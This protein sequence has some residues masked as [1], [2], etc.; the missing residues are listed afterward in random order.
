MDP[1]GFLPVVSGIADAI[2]GN[3]NAQQARDAYKSRYQDTVKDIK[4]AGLNPALAYGQGG[5]NPQTHD[6]PLPGEQTSKAAQQFGAANT[7]KQQAELIKTQND[8]LQAQKT[9]IILGTQLK[10]KLLNE[11]IGQTATSAQEGK[12]RINE[13]QA[14]V[15]QI[16]IA[17]QNA[18]MDYQWKSGSWDTRIAILHNQLKSSGLNITRQELELELRRLA[19][20]RLKAESKFYEGIGQASPY[21]NTGAQLLRIIRGF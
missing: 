11:Q 3:S 20:P 1:F 9:D 5:G 19:R 15:K 12:Q 2:T 21:V 14:R 18:Q 6:R 4:K 13:S 10:N 7:A 8:L 16:G 17:V